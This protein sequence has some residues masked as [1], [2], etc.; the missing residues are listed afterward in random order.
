MHPEAQKGWIAFKAEKQAF[1]NQVFYR[2]KWD[3]ESVIET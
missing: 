2:N 3:A 1:L